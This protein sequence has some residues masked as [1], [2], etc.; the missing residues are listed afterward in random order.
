MELLVILQLTRLFASFSVNFFLKFLRT[1][2][3]VIWREKI[4]LWDTL[5]LTANVLT[6]GYFLYSDVDVKCCKRKSE[7]ECE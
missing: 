7:K 1:D 6:I 2:F 5:M 3:T 4:L